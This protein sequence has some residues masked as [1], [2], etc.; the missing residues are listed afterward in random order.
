MG[1]SSKI[2]NRHMLVRSQ[3]MQGHFKN[4]MEMELKDKLFSVQKIRN[5][6]ITFNY[7]PFQ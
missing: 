1:H 7:T 6:Y 2:F 5:P 4:F 3:H